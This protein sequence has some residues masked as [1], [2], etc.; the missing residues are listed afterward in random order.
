MLGLARIGVVQQKG[1][2]LACSLS[3]AIPLLAL[4]R[5]AISHDIGPV[6]VRKIIVYPHFWSFETLKLPMD[7]VQIKGLRIKLAAYPF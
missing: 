2:P 5:F 4:R 6:V 3:A 7:F 1:T